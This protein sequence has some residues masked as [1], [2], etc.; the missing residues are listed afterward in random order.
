MR[1]VRQVLRLAWEA[2][3]GQRQIGRSLGM[4]PALC[5]TNSDSKLTDTWRYFGSCASFFL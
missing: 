2:E 5:A 4:S 1:K 3:L